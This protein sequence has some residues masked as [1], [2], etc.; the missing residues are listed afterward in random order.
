MPLLGGDLQFRLGQIDA[1]ESSYS[2]AKALDRKLVPA[3]LGLTRVYRCESL[4]RKAYEELRRAHDI[5]PNDVEVE[6]AWLSVLARSERLAAMQAYLAG[7][8]PDDR[9]AR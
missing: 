3:Y 2:D 5:A 6:Q 4:Y 7:P 1:A 8:H 9:L